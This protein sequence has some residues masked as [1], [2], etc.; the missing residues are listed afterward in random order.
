MDASDDEFVDYYAILQVSPNCDPRVL[1]SAY[2]QLA[3]RYH[4]DRTGSKDAT[5]FSR[6]TEAYGILRDPDKRGAYDLRHAQVAGRDA[7]DYRSA[8]EAEIEEK[9]AISDA[10]AHARILRFLYQKRRDNAQDAGVIAFYLQDM[11]GCSDEHFEFHRWYLKE[12]GFIAINEQGS[13]A[14]TIAGVDHVIAMSRGAA[15]EK[16][17]IA[18]SASD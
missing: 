7:A 13:L 3:K 6:L 2:H 11:L 16:L 4:P 12:K 14:I 17:R 8:E 1:E 18:Q 9:A 5:Q 15:A 10:E